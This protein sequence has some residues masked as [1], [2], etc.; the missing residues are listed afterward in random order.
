MA[1]ILRDATVL[2]H[3][4]NKGTAGR[5]GNKRT[6]GKQL[7]FKY[8]PPASSFT[9]I[10]QRRQKELEQLNYRLEKAFPGSMLLCK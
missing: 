3:A 8:R 1:L 2:S 9:Q 7:A 6:A 4:D 5:C 10:T